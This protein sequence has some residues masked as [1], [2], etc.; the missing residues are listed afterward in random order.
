MCFQ[1]QPFSRLMSRIFSASSSRFMSQ[2]S[3]LENG[4]GVLGI[5]QEAFQPPRQTAW[6]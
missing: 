3:N 5:I 2:E 1:V 4:V 6:A